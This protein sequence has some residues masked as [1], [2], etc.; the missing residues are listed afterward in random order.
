[1]YNYTGN[2]AVKVDQSVTGG[3]LFIGGQIQMEQVIN[4]AMG[5]TIS[6]ASSSFHF[7]AEGLFKTFRSHLL[8]AFNTPN[9]A[10]LVHVTGGSVGNWP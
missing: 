2:E 8:K 4:P 7:F 6:S 3:Y 1:M 10:A 9:N 5:Y